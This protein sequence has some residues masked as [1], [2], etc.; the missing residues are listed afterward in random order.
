LSLIAIGTVVLSIVWIIVSIILAGGISSIME[1]YQ[2]IM[3][4][5]GA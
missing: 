2:T 4:Q 5:Y 1:Q 3:D